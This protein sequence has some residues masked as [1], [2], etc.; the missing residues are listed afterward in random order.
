[1]TFSNQDIYTEPKTQEGC[2]GGLDFG[3]KNENKMNM[4]AQHSDPTLKT[5]CSGP[6]EMTPDVRTLEYCSSID[7]QSNIRT[8]YLHRHMCCVIL[9]P[10]DLSVCDHGDAS[11]RALKKCCILGVQ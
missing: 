9:Y 3:E 5:L 8:R 4:S 10:A 2:S 7:L 11:V 6:T 1:M